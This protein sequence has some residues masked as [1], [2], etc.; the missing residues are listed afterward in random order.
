M[1]RFA[2]G[3]VNENEGKILE[4]AELQLEDMI[5]TVV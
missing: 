3:Q 5:N 1:N 2:S 4:Y